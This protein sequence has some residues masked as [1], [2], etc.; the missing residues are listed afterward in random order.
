MVAKAIETTLLVHELKGCE[1]V[2]EYVW[3]EGT[4]SVLPLNESVFGVSAAA[5]AMM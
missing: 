2:R 3:L 1:F 5:A 4:L